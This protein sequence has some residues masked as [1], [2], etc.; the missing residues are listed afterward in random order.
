M[1]PALVREGGRSDIGRVPRGRAVQDLIEQS[2]H[3]RQARQLLAADTDFELCGIGLLEQKSRQ[4]CAQIGVAAT[5]AESVE[6]ALDLSGTAAY[7]R[8]GYGHG[9]LRVVVRVYA[10]R[11]RRQFRFD[12]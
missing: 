6:R 1:K 10:E 3:R 9:L 8:Q 7:R 4:Q 12:L 2:R 5:L 11:R